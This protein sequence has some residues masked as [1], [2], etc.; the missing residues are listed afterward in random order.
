MVVFPDPYLVRQVADMISAS[1]ANGGGSERARNEA[2]A[3]VA[4]AVEDLHQ[5]EKRRGLEYARVYL[6]VLSE[7]ADAGSVEWPY[8]HAAA[9][10]LLTSDEQGLDY[11]IRRFPSPLAFGGVLIPVPS[12]RSTWR[13][14]LQE[15]E[16]RRRKQVANQLRA[17]P[18]ERER[19]SH[20][21]E[22]LVLLADEVGKALATAVPFP[23]PAIL[24]HYADT[25]RPIRS[26]ALLQPIAQYV[27]NFIVRRSLSNATSEDRREAVEHHLR[28]FLEVPEGSEVT[29]HLARLG[30]NVRDNL[31]RV[32]RRTLD[33]VLQDTAVGRFGK[34]L[35]TY[36]SEI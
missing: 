11:R 10:S 15:L 3:Y 12:D 20:V 17:T 1:R 6:E 28:G 2:I 14:Y 33:S 16:R 18:E 8:T 36:R 25:G 34:P 29:D 5:S 13:E 24:T 23:D 21:M 7:N 9:Y 35:E 30:Y 22:A 19:S 27:A 4:L 26:D 32:D 31:V